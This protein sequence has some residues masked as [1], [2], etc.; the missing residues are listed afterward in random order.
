MINLAINLMINRQTRE[1]IAI[2]MIVKRIKLQSFRTE[3]KSY[4]M[5][6]PFTASKTIPFKV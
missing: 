3:S 4:K 5:K 6:Y 1:I 2:I